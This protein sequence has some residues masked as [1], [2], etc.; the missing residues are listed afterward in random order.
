MDIFHRSNANGSIR[1]TRD[2]YSQNDVTSD[3]VL[4]IWR[5]TRKSWSLFVSAYVI[6][7][8]LNPAPMQGRICLYGR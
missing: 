1:I 2:I 8:I 7:P 3:L 6:L 4:Y 5:L